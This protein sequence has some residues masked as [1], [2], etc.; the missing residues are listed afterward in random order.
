MPGLMGSA[1]CIYAILGL[2][3][4]RSN[5]LATASYTVQLAAGTNKDVVI[6]VGHPGSWPGAI[7]VHFASGVAW[8]VSR[9]DLIRPAP[10]SPT[11]R[12][13]PGGVPAQIPAFYRWGL[14]LREGECVLNF[15]YTCSQ[16]VSMN[17]ETNTG[18]LPAANP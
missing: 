2:N 16:D 5:R 12:V 8:T 1:F 14:L 6:N 17:V 15:R 11:T 4:E 7:Y 3:T 13:V 10:L 18:V 9:L